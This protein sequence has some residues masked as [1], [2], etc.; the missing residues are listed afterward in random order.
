MEELNMPIILNGKET[1]QKYN[2]NLKNSINELVQKGNRQPKLVVIQVGANPASSLYI[3]NK[4]RACERVGI[5]FDH[6]IF[7]EDVKETKVVETIKEL[8]KNNNVDGILVQ[9]PLPKTINEDFVINTISP[10]KD[11][12]GFCPVTLGN[13]ILN[14]SEIYPGT[15]KGI[16]LLLKEYNV[17]VEGK[18]VVVIGRSNIVGKPI[19]IMLTNMS[20]TVT[21]CHSKTKNLKDITKNADI[22]IVA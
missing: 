3:R 6:I 10:E 7:D 21:V 17:D 15:P 9:L 13:V 12:D 5:L 19:S 1:A 20:A 4:K 8:N 14:K 22:L 2:D 18:N 11:A 16:I